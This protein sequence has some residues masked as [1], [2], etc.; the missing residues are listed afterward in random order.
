M[1]KCNKSTNVVFDIICLF[2]W[3]FISYICFKYPEQITNM[4]NYLS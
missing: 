1:K 3:L 4:I 2:F